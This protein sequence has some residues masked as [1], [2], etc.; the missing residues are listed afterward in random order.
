[1]ITFGGCGGSS[2]IGRCTPITG[3]NG[4]VGDVGDVVGVNSKSGLE[5]VSVSDNALI[6]EVED[7]GEMPAVSVDRACDSLFCA[8]EGDSSRSL[9]M[10]D[11][12]HFC[13]STSITV[14]AP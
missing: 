14:E 9:G 12:D 8:V 2:A 13:D 1:M 7:A 11:E 10:I 5:W 3:D 6:D 4:S